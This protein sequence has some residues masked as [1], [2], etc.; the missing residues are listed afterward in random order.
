[1]SPVRPR[2]TSPSRGVRA[3]A[4]RLGWGLG[5]QAVSSLTNFAVSMFV[6]RELGV[7]AFGV[8]SL[9]WVTYAV[10]INLSRGLA[11]DPLM[12]RFSGVDTG[13]WR[14]GAAQASGTALAVG[15]VAGVLSVGAGLVIGSSLGWA[16]V[17]LGVVLPG[18]LVQDSWRFAFF[19]SGEGRKAF[20]NDVVW[21]VCLV[22]AMLVAAQHESVVAF[23]LAWGFSGAVAA[24]YGCVQT[25]VYPRLSRA[26]AWLREQRDL[27]FRYVI[28][29]VSNSGGSQLRMYGL[30]AIAGLADVG[31]V[32]GAELLMGP[33]LAVLFGLSAVTVAEAAR[34]LQR[35]PQR[36]WPFC[37][38]LGAGQAIVALA[39]GVALMIL[40]PDAVGEYLL[41][42]VWTVA[43]PLILPATLGVVGASFFTGAAAGL[44]ALGMA[45]RSLRAQLVFS[46]AYVIGGLAGAA[47]GGA[48]GSEWGTAIASL[49]GS[50]V[51]WFQLHRGLRDHLSTEVRTSP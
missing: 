6:A 47:A 37:L 29:N 49:L 43:A 17:A 44:R 10:L 42:D 33:F 27:G 18:L 39:W 24:L 28:E 11:T 5:D 36:L 22:P 26:R 7:T 41:G 3:M 40:L 35:S 4:G 9:A 14:R 34:V 51:W 46:A 13:R 48:L 50:A 45:R 12:V 31:V 1:M 8:F 25:G 20:V 21:G 16:F 15:A 38:T 2:F 30:G 23:L 19:A 32:R